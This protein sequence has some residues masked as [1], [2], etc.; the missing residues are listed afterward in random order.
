MQIKNG[1]FVHKAIVMMHHNN[2]AQILAM[3]LHKLNNAIVQCS[4]MSEYFLMWFI[5]ILVSA[6]N[7]F[8]ISI[9]FFLLFIKQLRQLATSVTWLVD[10]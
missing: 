7:I 8:V 2:I 4:K 3:Y 5:I 6:M 1:N 10:F 9:F